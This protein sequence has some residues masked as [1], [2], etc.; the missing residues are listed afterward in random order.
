M[1]AWTLRF[2]TKNIPSHLELYQCLALSLFLKVDRWWGNDCHDRSYSTI[3][4]GA[5]DCLKDEWSDAGRDAYLCQLKGLEAMASSWNSPDCEDE[6]LENH[7]ECEWDRRTL[8]QKLTRDVLDRALAFIK[9]PNFDSTGDSAAGKTG[10][11]RPGG[12]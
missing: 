10:S 7:K 4:K 11:T 2:E 8:P 9:N 1:R 12:P 3:E 6:L 5:V